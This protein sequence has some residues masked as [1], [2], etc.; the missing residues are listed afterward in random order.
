MNTG[1]ISDIRTFKPRDL[2]RI[3]TTN[4]KYVSMWM[5]SQCCFYTVR[6]YF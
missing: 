5:G 2:L 4:E 1:N 3:K 6:E